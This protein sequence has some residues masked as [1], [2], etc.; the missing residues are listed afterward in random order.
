M[1]K[2]SGVMYNS[3][4]MR[5]WIKNWSWYMYGCQW[6]R[7]LETDSLFAEMFPEMVN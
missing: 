6:G 2:E 3:I 5:T 7:Y 4:A 1:F